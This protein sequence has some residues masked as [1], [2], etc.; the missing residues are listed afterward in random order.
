[1]IFLR[2]GQSKAA[3]IFIVC[4]DQNE[5]F[6]VTVR[7]S[8]ASSKMTVERVFRAVLS[9]VSSNA[10]CASLLDKVNRDWLHLIQRFRVVIA[11]AVDDL[12][13]AQP[14]VGSAPHCSMASDW[15]LASVSS[16]YLIQDSA[17]VAAKPLN[18]PKR[19][20]VAFRFDSFR[21]DSP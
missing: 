5:P 8:T 21:L 12:R 7:V 2:N 11:G 9:S 18:M 1:M 14:F 3:A 13:R 16:K 10:F 20:R 15:S 4:A 17:Q 19:H 6:E